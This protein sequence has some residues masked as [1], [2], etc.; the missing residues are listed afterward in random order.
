MTDESD[1]FEWTRHQPPLNADLIEELLALWAGVFQYSFQEAEQLLLGEEVGEN[2]DVIYVARDGVQIAGTCHLT[3]SRA[4]PRLGGLGEVAVP[5]EFRRQ[6]LAT[7]L[8]EQARDEF[9]ARGGE[10][11]FLGTVNPGARRIYER[12]GWRQ[13]TGATVMVCSK[14][15]T[16]PDEFLEQ[17]L[18]PNPGPWNVRVATSAIRVPM[19][20]LALAD[21]PWTILDAN[22]GLCSTRH[23]E[24]NSC[25]GLYA[26]YEQVMKQGAAFASWTDDNQ[27]LGLATVKMDGT[28]ARV[29]AFTHAFEQFGDRW[30]KLICRAVKW[31]AERP[32]SECIAL[33]AAANETKQDAFRSVDFVEVS[34]DDDIVIGER[35]IETKRF[36]FGF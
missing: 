8:C 1:H 32:I 36:R 4:D 25:M 3:I 29:D 30:Q 6:G 19:I 13:L 14:Q 20:P 7:K 11:L 23:V 21:H 24:Q 33:I 5:D 28:V 34:S 22:A 12:L 17:W 10:A 2:T 27:L 26:R 9:F 16:P 15:S 35:T 31:T 18:R